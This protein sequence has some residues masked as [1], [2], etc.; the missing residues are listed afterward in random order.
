MAAIR[1]LI[2]PRFAFISRDFWASPMWMENFH[3]KV[4]PL[5]DSITEGTIQSW[6]KKPNDFVAADEVI[7]VLE[8]D[9]VFVFT[10]Q[11]NLLSSPFTLLLLPSHYIQLKHILLF[12]RRK[13]DLKS[14]I[15]KPPIFISTS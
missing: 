4:P 9:K 1:K 5:G 3:L 8:T 6:L 15:D 14:A 12:S 11:P 2:H 10:F 13:K 7:V